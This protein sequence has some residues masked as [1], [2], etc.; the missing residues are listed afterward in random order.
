MLA[1]TLGQ[2]RAAAQA[3]GDLEQARSLFAQGLEAAQQESWTRAAELFQRS[4]AILPLATTLVNL[5]TAQE[6]AGLLVESLASVERLLAGDEAELRR[7]RPQLRAQADGLRGRVAR[8]IVRVQGLQA[9]DR[10]RIDERELSADELD[11]EIA[12][13]PGERRIVVMRADRVASSR[14]ITLAEGAREVVPLD[15]SAALPLE[16]APVP[17]C[18]GCGGGPDWIW[19][20]VGIGAGAAVL[21]GVL[22]GLGVGLQQ[23]GRFVGNLGP[24]FLVFE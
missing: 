6:R 14:S 16:P 22:I 15:V 24:G 9:A 3:P 23:D 19:W 12:I 8:V 4:Y 17:P 13:N 5:A 21:A 2:A 20:I 11:S 18:D 10:V 1:A 7:L